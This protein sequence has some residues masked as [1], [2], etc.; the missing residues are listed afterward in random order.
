MAR[1]T[2]VTVGMDRGKEVEIQHGL[3]ATDLVLADAKGLRVE[4]VPLEVKA[5]AESK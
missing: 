5:K 4:E 3:K 2:R 1:Q